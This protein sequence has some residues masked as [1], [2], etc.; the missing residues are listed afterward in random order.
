[1]T[2]TDTSNAAA[3]NAVGKLTKGSK[4]KRRMARSADA[5]SEAQADSAAIA[6]TS[7]KPAP[8]KPNKAPLITKSA[9]VIALLQR[10]EGATLPELIA[11][12]GWLPHTTRAALTGLKKKG[13]VIVRDKRG[14]VTCYCIAPAAA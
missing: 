5:E 13:H 4:P 6:D 10:D 11:A 7:T 1:M 9:S 12:T 3:K 8:S 2:T 14:D